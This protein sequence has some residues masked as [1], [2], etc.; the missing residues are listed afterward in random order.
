MAF[1]GTC[2]C[3]KIIKKICEKFCIYIFILYL[4]EIN[5]QTHFTTVKTILNYI[6][7]LVL[8]LSAGVVG[9][10]AAPAA[11]GSDIAVRETVIKVENHAIVVENSSDTAVEVAVFSITGTMVKNI[12]VAPGERTEIEVNTGFY[13]V[14]AGK[15]SQRVAVR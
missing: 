10:Y 5:R 14:K 4:C 11:Y 15:H 3:S 1:E 13:I 7:G 12:S 6:A 8:C 9:A 2:H